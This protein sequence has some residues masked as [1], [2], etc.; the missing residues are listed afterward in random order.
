MY[1]SVH[2]KNYA[3]PF[4]IMILTYSHMDDDIQLAIVVNLALK[5]KAAPG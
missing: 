3:L 5:S 4:S 2:G 1:E